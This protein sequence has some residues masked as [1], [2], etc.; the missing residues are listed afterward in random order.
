MSLLLLLAGCFP[1]EGRDWDSAPWLAGDADTD[2]DADSD[3][4][5]DADADSDSDSDSDTDS[6][7]DADTDYDGDGYTVSEGDCDDEDRNVHPGADEYCN[8]DDDDC[9][10]SY[11]EDFDGDP[12]EPNDEDLTDLGDLT[13]VGDKLSAYISP[14]DDVDMFMF[15]LED[16]TWDYF[17]FDLIVTPPSSVDVVVELWWYPDDTTG[18]EWLDTMDAAGAGGEED[19]YREG[20]YWDDDSAWYAAVIYANSGQSCSSNYAFEVF[21]P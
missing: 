3:T 1:Y 2:A 12:Y 4:D 21:L 6:D 20:D 17:D 18:W 10:G 11:D 8:G 5:S 7:A 13:D 19:L 15:Y 9:D 16:G 14:A